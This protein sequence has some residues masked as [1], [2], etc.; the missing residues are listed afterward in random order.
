MRAASDE[1]ARLTRECD[2]F[3]EPP[4]ARAEE[5]LL[6][7][8]A[9]DPGA[10][11]DAL[12]VADEALE[13]AGAAALTTKHDF[14]SASAEEESAASR[15]RNHPDRRLV[16]LPDPLPADLA[17][18][19]AAY[20]AEVE[21]QARETAQETEFENLGRQ[22]REEIQRQQAAHDQLDSFASM[23]GRELADDAEFG[24]GEPAPPPF[25]GS[26]DRGRGVFEDAIDE[27]RAQAAAVQAAREAVGESG[28]RIQHFV[29]EP[30]FTPLATNA[31][32]ARLES[33][34][35]AADA[36]YLAGELRK[37]ERVLR[38]SLDQIA[39]HKQTAV[40]ELAANVERARQDLRAAQRLSQLP[41]GLGAWA[42]KQFLRIDADWWTSDEELRA[43]LGVVVEEVAHGEQQRLSGIPLLV[44]AL[45]GA[46]GR[47][48]F[49]SRLLKPAISDR[50]EY[51]VV[52]EAGGTSSGGQGATLAILLYCSLCALRAH[53]R[54]ARAASRTTLVLDNPI[55]KASADF[56][57]EKQRAVATALGVQLIYTTGVNDLGALDHFPKL[58][59]LRN[60]QEL[61]QASRYVHLDSER[62]NALLAGRNG[63]TNGNGYLA[64]AQL[65]ER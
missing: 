45:E 26:A 47:N 58:I 38:D 16:D 13:G 61:R 8:Q 43:R 20:A 2:G 46:V 23:L 28:R 51:V 50:G 37:R 3:G 48:G 10:R 44:R 15:A 63:S 22:A 36:A 6:S 5:L 25:T 9:S 59:R 34:R 52:T 40:S 53:N 19:Q 29:Y 12:R 4:R 27:L 42:G 65:F 55:G 14:E 30:R 32:R 56:L 24:E 7:E 11:K 64:A 35:L 54:G 33:E 57:I 62:L 1:E 18:A 41:D 39:V 60:D 21:L 49:R 31:L 17:S